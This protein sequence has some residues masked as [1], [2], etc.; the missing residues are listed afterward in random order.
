MDLDHPPERVWRA[1]TDPRQLAEWF[2]PADVD[3][4]DRNRLHLRP[5]HFDGFT[6]PVD[7]EVVEAVSPER[8]V[9]RWEGDDL[10]VRVAVT[11]APAGDGSRLT[12]VQ[13]GYLGRRGTLRRRMLRSTYARL[14]AERLPRTLDRIAGQESTVLIAPRTGAQPANAPAAPRSAARWRNDAGFQRRRVRRFEARDVPELP[15]VPEVPSR[16]R[17]SAPDD[18]PAPF[19]PRQGGM[20]RP[21]VP[22]PAVA[23]VGAAPQAVPDVPDRAFTGAGNRTVTRSAHRARRRAAHRF[24]EPS[25]GTPRAGARGVAVVP[26]TGR[27][28]R[29]A[30]AWLAAQPEGRRHRA[31]AVPYRRGGNTRWIRRFVAVRPIAG[32]QSQPLHGVGRRRRHG[33]G[34]HSAG[35]FAHRLRRIGTGRAS[36]IRLRAR[37]ARLRAGAARAAGLRAGAAR[38]ARPP[39]TMM[40]LGAAV[41][42]VMAVGA[43]VAARM[44]APRA[45]SPQ[46]G[47][48]AE[49]PPGFAGSP[50]PDSARA[51]LAGSYRTASTW[52]GGYTGEII[53]R[54]GG[55]AGVDGWTS[56]ITLPML[57]ITVEAADGAQ[58]RQDGRSVTFTPVP[59]TGAVS[60]H[61]EVRFGFTV[62][63]DGP[64]TAC[65]VD[66]R[67]CDGVSG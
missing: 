35:W 34:S 58:V 61:G 54:N 20:L 2:L 21:A 15:A 16:G 10:H 51:P 22:I 30:A 43:V 5:A 33:I 64:P 1:L 57:G 62:N 66:G 44:S 28:A 39:A 67:P 42:L 56:M 65:T 7:V 36:A 37:T 32:E 40:A 53:I 48:A 18:A 27:P 9:C 11:I 38:A 19:V 23:A 63:G 26:G 14:F 41:L 60:A 24:A 6:G 25:R 59:A 46:V 12:F 49:P 50:V 55:D 45:A 47:G 17:H 4:A 8:L 52:A 3:P 13:R 29:P 31:V